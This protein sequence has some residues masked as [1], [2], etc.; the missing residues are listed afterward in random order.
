MRPTLSKRASSFQVEAGVSLTH[1]TF[2]PPHRRGQKRKKPRCPQGGSVGLTCRTFPYFC[3]NVNQACE[4]TWSFSFSLI[5]ELE[6]TCDCF[7]LLRRKHFNHYI[8]VLSFGPKVFAREPRFRSRLF[9]YSETIH[10][11]PHSLFDRWDLKK[12]SKLKC[13]PMV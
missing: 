9:D 2:S 10:H 11:K 1:G 13:T 5:W 4:E 12:S 6:K 7:R 3:C 8:S